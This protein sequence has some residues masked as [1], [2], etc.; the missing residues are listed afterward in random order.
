[1]TSID[2]V[3]AAPPTPHRKTWF[4]VGIVAVLTLV[5]V[6]VI[7]RP[8]RADDG[9]VVQN[10]GCPFT[11]AD[12]VDEEVITSDPFTGAQRWHVRTSDGRAWTLVEIGRSDEGNYQPM[13]TCYQGFLP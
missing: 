4:I 2:P 12:I 13:V 5:T 7:W 8:G 3:S 1:M 9:I 10:V 6:L 11:Q